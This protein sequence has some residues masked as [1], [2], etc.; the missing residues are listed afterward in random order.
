MTEA[1]G[2]TIGA[3]GDLVE[4]LQQ[5]TNGF[6]VIRFEGSENPLVLDAAQVREA[7]VQIRRRYGI[8]AM[9]RVR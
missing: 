1:N 7:D 9:T 2:R 5:P 4:A 3:L 6:Q 8:P